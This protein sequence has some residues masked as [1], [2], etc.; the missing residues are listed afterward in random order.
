MTGLRPGP[1]AAFLPEHLFEHVFM[2]NLSIYLS[3][4]WFFN[5]RRTN[6]EVPIV[7]YIYIYT[8]W[9]RLRLGT[10]AP[11]YLASGGSWGGLGEG[12][13]RSRKG[14]NFL[15]KN[16]PKSVKNRFQNRSKMNQKS[17]SKSIENLMHLGMDFWKDF[18]GFWEAK[19]SNVGIKFGA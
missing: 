4:Y 17:M 3:I 18:G 9:G 7:W 14:Y 12:L 15:P 6:N 16:L 8:N 13:R 2:I 11:L 5:R 19:W 10:A 1:G